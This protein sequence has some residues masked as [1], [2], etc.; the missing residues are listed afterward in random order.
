M[1]KVLILGSTGMLGRAVVREFSGLNYNLTITSRPGARTEIVPNAKVVSFDAEKQ[2]LA[3]IPDQNYDFII[4]CIGLIKSEIKDLSATSLKSAVDL[5]INLPIALSDFAARTGAK[6]IQIATDC[7]YSGSKGSYLESDPHDALDV[8]GKTK[9][10]G[11]VPSN[12]MMHIRVSIIGKEN[13][14]H[15]SL[16]DWV[17]LQPSN[18]SITGYTDHLWNG[19]PATTFAEV[20]RVII[21][22]ELFQTGVHHLVPSNAVSKAELVSLIAHQE[23]RNDLKISP[24]PSGTPIDRTL[25]T[26]DPEFSRQIWQ[27]LGHKQ[28]P[29]IQDLVS[30]I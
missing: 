15:T 24:E 30:K 20:C 23:G 17:R 1:K 10:L 16:Y 29:S 5:N 18:A 9:S 8:Y 13:R 21:A 27:V 28:V 6:I 2:T 25:S 26:I 4:N 12:Q 7:V 22:E 19:I 11:E 3:S 14:G